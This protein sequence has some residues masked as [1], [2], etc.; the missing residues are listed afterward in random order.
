LLATFALLPGTTPALAH[1][2]KVFAT[3]IGTT[4]EG[5]AYFVG[6]GAA[7]DVPVTLSDSTGAVA[8]TTKTHAP[9]GTFSL[10]LPYL[11]DFT[12]TADAQDGH[13][14]KFALTAARLTKTLP[15]APH[16]GVAEGSPTANVPVAAAAPE[17]VSSANI[18]AI[19]QAVA[20]QVAPLTD[21]I[22]TMQATIG[23]RDVLG[24]IGFVLGI[25]GLWSLLARRG[26]AP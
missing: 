1:K 8:G 18:D 16:V 19:E 7:S 2:L 14:A 25:F 12:I 10:T 3:A 9:D 11:D 24:G 6:G 5:R 15:V 13:V 23:F 20:R 4:L 21:Q 17:T 22:D 26:K